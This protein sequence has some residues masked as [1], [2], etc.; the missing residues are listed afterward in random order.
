[1][2][3]P[4]STTPSSEA[5]PGARPTESGVTQQ[6]R[7]RRYQRAL[8]GWL[9]TRMRTQAHKRWRSSQEDPPRR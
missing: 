2:T 9:A 3:D 1:M 7:E 8:A 4:Q 6:S 5:Q